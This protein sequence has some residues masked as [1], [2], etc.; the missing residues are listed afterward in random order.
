MLVYCDL[1]YLTYY[2]LQVEKDQMANKVVD[3]VESPYASYGQCGVGHTS[4]LANTLK[5]LKEEIR[6]CKLD[7]D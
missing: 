3:Y 5:S 2:V 7:N 1:V 6:S 4:D